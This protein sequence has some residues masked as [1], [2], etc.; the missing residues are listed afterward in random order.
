MLLKLYIFGY[1]NSSKASNQIKQ[2]KQ[3]RIILKIEV[4]NKQVIVMFD[5]LQKHS[6]QDYYKAHTQI[7]NISDVT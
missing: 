6:L 3:Q 4:K 2:E 1:L 5:R 7:R